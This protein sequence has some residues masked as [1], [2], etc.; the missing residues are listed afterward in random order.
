ME[1]PFPQAC[2]SS[3][4]PCISSVGELLSTSDPDSESDVRTSEGF[5]PVLSVAPTT[6]TLP[7][8][9]R[10]NYYTDLK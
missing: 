7:P 1:D 10:H 8:E 3:A 6:P 9:S 5:V 4:G 2:C